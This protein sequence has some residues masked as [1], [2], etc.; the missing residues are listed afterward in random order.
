M[1]HP[2]GLAR[3]PM[4]SVATV[5]VLIGCGAASGVATTL[6]RA[7]ACE[8]F[9]LPGISGDGTDAECVPPEQL[10]L[11]ESATHWQQNGRALEAANCFVGAYEESDPPDP[12]LAYRAGRAYHEAGQ[13]DLARS[14]Y[15]RVIASTADDAI[16]ADARRGL[17]ELEAH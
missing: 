6:P 7:G 1:F 2:G 5:L 4:R 16:A 11:T 3:L 15:E 14:W 9:E 13:V 8:P 10:G 17:A 12:W